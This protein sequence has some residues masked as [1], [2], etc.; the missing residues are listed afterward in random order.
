MARETINIIFFC[1]ISM[2][3]IC[4]YCI[5]YK[6]TETVYVKISWILN[7]RYVKSLALKSAYKCIS[8]NNLTNQ[9]A[10][11]QNKYCDSIQISVNCC[12]YIRGWNIK[13]GYP[14]IYCRSHDKLIYTTSS[15]RLGI[16]GFPTHLISE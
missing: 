11:C 13:F 2:Y 4:N 1:F 3:C 15:N 7:S 12:S 9:Y 16:Y 5:Y 8:C 10:F 14:L 6:E